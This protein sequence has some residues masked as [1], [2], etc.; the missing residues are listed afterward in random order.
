MADPLVIRD[1]QEQKV[2]RKEV[3][4]SF[5]HVAFTELL[6]LQTEIMDT[7]ARVCI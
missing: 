2:L 6:G 7:C 4:F 1:S 5:E 3:K